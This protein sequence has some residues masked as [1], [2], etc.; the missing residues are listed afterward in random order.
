MTANKHHADY[1]VQTRFQDCGWEDFQISIS[2]KTPYVWTHLDDAVEWS[3]FLAKDAFNGMIRVVDRWGRFDRTWSAG[4]NMPKRE[5]KI[6]EYSGWNEKDA[7]IATGTGINEIMEYTN[8][9]SQSGEF[10]SN[11]IREQ[12]N[13]PL[14]EKPMSNTPPK[15][16]S[17]WAVWITSMD[18][19]IVLVGALT[20]I[21][22]MGWWTADV[23][24]SVTKSEW[25]NRPVAAPVV[26]DEVVMASLD[27]IEQRISEFMI[28]ASNTNIRMHRI[29]QQLETLRNRTDYKA[30]ELLQR[31]VKAIKENAAMPVFFDA[32]G[33][34]KKDWWPEK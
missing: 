20:L 28:H 31:Q 33:Q 9:P 18:P 13:L 16:M 24:Q 29:E 30:V 3:N 1:K 32:D 5:E 10:S 26:K 14:V 22:G 12:M 34:P 6:G 23:V 8:L 7:R 4:E 25:W 27:H 17:I 21:F 15:K 19:E 2:G 11:E